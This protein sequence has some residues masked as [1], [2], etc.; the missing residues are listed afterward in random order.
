MK[1]KAKKK[2]DRPQPAPEKSPPPH[3]P[4]PKEIENGRKVLAILENIADIGYTVY[5]QDLFTVEEPEFGLQ[6]TVD[7]E[8]EVICL[9]AEICGTEHM[10]ANVPHW[11]E[12]LLQLNNRFLHGAFSLDGE[13]VLLRENLAAENLDANELEDALGAMFAGII[14]YAH[15]LGLK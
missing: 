5:R 9:V 6:I 2:P 4:S 10:K 1:T 8:E 12:K 11:P 14:R 7:A 15:E 13:K 3:V